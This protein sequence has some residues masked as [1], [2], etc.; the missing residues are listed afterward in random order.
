MVDVD[1]LVDVEVDVDLVLLL[2]VE[3]LDVVDLAV[4]VLEV[5]VDSV[6]LVVVEGKFYL[7]FS[8]HRQLIVKLSLI[9]HSKRNSNDH[10]LTLCFF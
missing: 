3:D 4:E 9:L 2:V 10:L 5:D 7:L 8:L 6:L 1:L